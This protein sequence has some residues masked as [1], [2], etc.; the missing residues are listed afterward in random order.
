MSERATEAD[1]LVL[2]RQTV[3]APAVTGIAVVLLVELASN[4]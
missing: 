3:D 4:P 1:A 2:L